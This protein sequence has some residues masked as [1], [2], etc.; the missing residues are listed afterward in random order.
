ME[1]TERFRFAYDPGV[2]R[3]GEQSVEALGEELTALG[4][5]G[6]LVVCGE[7]VGSTPAVIDPVRN[8][9]GARLAGVFDRTTPEKRL[10]T[11]A[12]AA[13]QFHQTG[14]DA[15][16][17][18]GGGSS[19]DVAKVASVIA[20]GDR[21]PSKLGAQLESTGRI[22]ISAGELPPVLAVPT[23]LA[24]ADF[25][26]LAGITASAASGLVSEDVSGGLSDPRLMPAAALYDPALVR[27][28]PQSVLS[29]SAMNGFDKGIETLYARS[30]TPITDATALRGLGL[31]VEGLPTLASE[32]ERWD[33]DSILRGLVLVQYGISRPDGT[34]LS[35]VHALGHG[36]KSHADVH[37]GVAHA[38]LA[39]HALAYLFERVDGQRELLAEALN[40]PAA[41]DPAQGTITAVESVRDSLGLPSR[42]RDI[43]GIDR[44]TFDAIAQTTV[45]DALIENVPPGLDPERS[46]LRTVLEAAW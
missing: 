12:E 22:T 44:S 18:L 13:A 28:T 45:D 17:A 14:A 40:V 32:R 4:C 30:R 25:S 15:F 9:L 24:G 1:D 23:T 11:A 7:T 19:I 27:T 29:A 26:Q 35:L 2:I 36:V 41:T 20:S 43:D 39:P 10:E 31:L 38:V 37:Q 3:F 16:V 42:L 46:E 21:D 33:L 5:S 6:A 8:G 34:T